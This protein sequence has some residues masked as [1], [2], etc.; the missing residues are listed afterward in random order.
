MEK[1]IVNEY[2]ILFPF[3]KKVN[4]VFLVVLVGSL[5]V[6]SILPII[7]SVFHFNDVLFCCIEGFALFTFIY[8]FAILLYFKIEMDEVKIRYDL[9]YLITGYVWQQPE[10]SR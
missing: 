8:N 7:Y 3:L 9:R 2:N 6:L 4:K 1:E 5:I 10:V